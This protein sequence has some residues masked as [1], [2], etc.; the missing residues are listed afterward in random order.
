MRVKTAI[1]ATMIVGA[2]LLTTQGVANAALS[3]CNSNNM[4]M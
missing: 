1:A 2:S 4:C 3:D